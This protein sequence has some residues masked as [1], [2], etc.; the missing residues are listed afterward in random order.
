MLNV[1]AAVSSE[2]H[3]VNEV[4]VLNKLTKPTCV[5]VSVAMFFH[6]ITV[7]ID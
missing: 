5:T 2:L 7:L 4:D 1:T 3:V 6:H